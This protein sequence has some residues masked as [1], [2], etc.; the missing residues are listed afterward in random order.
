MPPMPKLK[1]T[2]FVSL[3]FLPL[4]NVIRNLRARLY[5]YHSINHAHVKIMGFS[6]ILVIFHAHLYESYVCLR[7]HFLAQT[8]CHFSLYL[9]FEV[10]HVDQVMEMQS[11]VPDPGAAHTLPWSLV[12]PF[13]LA[14]DIHRN[15]TFSFWV[16]QQHSLL[17]VLS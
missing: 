2:I 6:D 14:S 8:Y 11:P 3:Q 12:S 1:K 15:V 10:S 16:R 9:H 7:T 13:R 4:L 5:N 17:L